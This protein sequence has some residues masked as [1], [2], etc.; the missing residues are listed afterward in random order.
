MKNFLNGKLTVDNF[1]DEF[2]W[3]QRND[4]DRVDSSYEPHIPETGFGKWLNDIFFC[5][6]DFDDE[7]GKNDNQQ[8]LTLTNSRNKSYLL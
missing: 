2:F 4:R 7:A 1:T 5:C 3:L 8:L 6:E